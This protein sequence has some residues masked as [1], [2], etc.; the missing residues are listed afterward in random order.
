LAVLV[1]IQR[2]DFVLVCEDWIELLKEAIKI[3]AE[4]FT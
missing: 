1:E 2:S 4:D 3:G